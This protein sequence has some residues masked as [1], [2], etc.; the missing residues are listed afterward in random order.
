MIRKILQ[1]GERNATEEN[2]TQH[3]TR[4]HI[5]LSH[6]QQRRKKTTLGRME[7]NPPKLKKNLEN[8]RSTKLRFSKMPS[9][10]HNKKINS[11]SRNTGHL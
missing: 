5:H 9:I 1:D 7:E 6:I 11:K 4:R 3:K 10:S 8:N 2:E